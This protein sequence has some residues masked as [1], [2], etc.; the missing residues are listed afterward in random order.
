[1]QTNEIYKVVLKPRDK[2]VAVTFKAAR[3]SAV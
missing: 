1:M 2:N 3:G